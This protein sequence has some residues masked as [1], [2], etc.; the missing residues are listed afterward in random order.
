[1]AIVAQ[2]LLFF[3][4]GAFIFIIQVSQDSDKNIQHTFSWSLLLIGF[5]ALLVARFINIYLLTLIGYLIIGSKKW[6]LNVYEYQIMTVS[7]LVKGA[8]PFALILTLPTGQFHFSTTCVQNT[9][10]VIVFLSS[11]FLNSMMPKLIR[12]RL[13]KIDEM[14]RFNIDHPSLYDSLLI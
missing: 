1:M 2:G 7:G 10:I 12:N 13:N 11:L 3:L 14:I 9:V 8:V 6:K 4:L 5:L